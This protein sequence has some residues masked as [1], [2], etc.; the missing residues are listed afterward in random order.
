MKLVK[1]IA[2]KETHGSEKEIHINPDH[3][4]VIEKD[5]S[6]NK[7][8]LSFNNGGLFVVTDTVEEVLA[9]LK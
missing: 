6:T 4:S 3:I 2:N 9:K 8:R 1:L 5:N 7:A